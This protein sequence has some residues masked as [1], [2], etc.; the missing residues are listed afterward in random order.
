[1]RVLKW[2]FGGALGVLERFGIGGIPS[3]ILRAAK[4][5]VLIHRYP[6]PEDG[7]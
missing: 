1:M 4:G 6:P 3:R 2:G 5:P 7:A